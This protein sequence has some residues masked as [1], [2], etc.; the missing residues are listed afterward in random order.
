MFRIAF[1][2]ALSALPAAGAMA[3]DVCSTAC[4]N[5]A[6]VVGATSFSLQQ[7]LDSQLDW[8]SYYLDRQG[9]GPSSTPQGKEQGRSSAAAA[10]PAD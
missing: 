2:L 6:P 8:R 5:G 10:A 9:A 1:T 3:A 4:G 7:Y